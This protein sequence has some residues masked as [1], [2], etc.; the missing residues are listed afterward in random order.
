[1]AIYFLYK[2]Q[3]KYDIIGIQTHPPKGKDSSLNASSENKNCL[4]QATHF[5]NSILLQIR[6]TCEMDSTYEV[7]LQRTK[8]NSRYQ[9]SHWAGNLGNTGGDYDDE[10]EAFVET[11]YLIISGYQVGRWCRS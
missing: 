3:Y 8:P 10:E 2:I 5:T 4:L 6:T 9:R 7:Y 1:M 11:I